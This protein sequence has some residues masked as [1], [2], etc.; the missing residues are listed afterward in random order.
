MLSFS[1]S[2]I[3]QRSAK[4]MFGKTLAILGAVGAL[5]LW[6]AVA[7]AQ[8]ITVTTLTDSADPPFDGDSVCPAGVI[9][10]LPGADGEVSLREAIIAANNTP[11]PQT[12]TFAS[13]GTIFLSFDDADGDADPDLLPYLC[14]GETTI[15]GDLDGDN[16][17][18]ITLDGSLFTDPGADGLTMI[19][20][21]NTINGLQLQNIP[22][23]GL[24]V[25]HNAPGVTLKNNTI[26]NNIVTGGTL[27]IIIQNEGGT[28]KKTTISGNTVSGAVI[29]GI[30]VFTSDLPKAKISG[31]TITGNTIYANARFGIRFLTNFTPAGTGSKITSTKIIN[32]TITDNISAG[33]VF[34]MAGTK[35]VIAGTT[36]VGNTVTGS[37]IGM[38]LDGGIFGAKKN[39]LQATIKNNTVTGNTSTATA[40]ILVRS[41]VVDAVGNKTTVKIEKNTVSDNLLGRGI[42]VTAG[43]NNSSN[44]K[45]TANISTNTVERNGGIGI[46]GLG[47]LGAFTGAGTSTGN[48]L[49]INIGK[50]K[51]HDHTASGI[52]GIVVAGGAGSEDGAVDKIAN[53]NSVKATVSNNEV[54]NSNAYGVLV[55]GALSGEANS[56]DIGAQVS[57]NVVCSNGTDIQ[58]FGGAPDAPTT[59]GTG[60]TADAKITKNTA[61]SIAVADGVAGNIAT[62]TQDDNVPCP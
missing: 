28:I 59:V 24:S 46:S 60:N 45:L 47:G 43:Q 61:T 50:N 48:S 22:E 33:I 62:A 37:S 1:F 57:K 53:S 20:S 51:V 7:S 27:P 11:G 34:Q 56:N 58:V 42:R 9:G 40:G 29:D 13:E 32:N 49:N 10:D 25:F 35:S 3:W 18:D 41:G 2:A 36:I 19:S 4:R 8:T 17:P 26:S 14:G 38:N 55:T 15:N 16:V 52:S 23:V 54:T 5:S 21:G 31:T 44:N 39:T 30:L 6:V 12:I